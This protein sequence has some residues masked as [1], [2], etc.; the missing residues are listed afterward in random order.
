MGLTR[1]AV[2]GVMLTLL[3]I[4]MLTLVYNVLTVKAEG[5]I[6]TITFEELYP[7]GP[8]GDPQSLIGS[9]YEDLGVIFGS[10]WYAYGE[11]PNYPA[12]SGS[13]TAIGFPFPAVID[14][15]IPVS[16]V[17]AYFNVYS[18]GY[19]DN[20]LTFSAYS[21]TAL[22]GSVAIQPNPNLHLEDQFSILFPLIQLPG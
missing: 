16:N 8:V 20:T 1:K 18:A 12:H 4:G 9:Y 11:D 22:L 14:F 7:G 19:E 10:D 13:I 17:S 21:G 3:F 6:T 15:T 2:S 5:N